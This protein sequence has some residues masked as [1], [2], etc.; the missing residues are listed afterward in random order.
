MAFYAFEFEVPANTLESAPLITTKQV[1]AGTL[2]RLVVIIPNGHQGLAR[3]RIEDRATAILPT[4]GS[5]PPWIRG[6]GSTID[7][8]PNLALE[9]PEW[10]IRMIGWNEDAAFSHAFI[11]YM[12]VQ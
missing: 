3:L 7:M 4:Q 12:E 9:G 6:D 8:Q 10:T 5:D 11:V 1:M 2:R